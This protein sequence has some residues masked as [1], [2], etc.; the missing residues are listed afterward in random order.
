MTGRGWAKLSGR[1][2]AKGRSGHPDRPFRKFAWNRGRPLGLSRHS[3]YRITIRSSSRSTWLRFR[4][5]DASCPSPCGV[6]ALRASPHAVRAGRTWEGM[7]E[8]FAAT[9]FGRGGLV[10]P[11]ESTLRC[12]PNADRPRLVTAGEAHAN[13]TP[14]SDARHLLRLLSA[15]RRPELGAFVCRHPGQVHLASS[16]PRVKLAP[17]AR[18]YLHD[19][20]RTWDIPLK[21]CTSHDPERLHR[22]RQA[23]MIAH[24][25][26]ESSLQLLVRSAAFDRT[27]SPRASAL[28]PR[29]WIPEE[30]RD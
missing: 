27:G 16:S 15:L 12:P 24:P 20:S 1:Q 17:H 18:P 25:H 2:K 6:D 8:L 5:H 22:Y 3:S 14:S 4:V 23:R 19:Q 21:E 30:A 26:L 28:G 10:H 29:Q 13:H 9:C 11:L 7:V